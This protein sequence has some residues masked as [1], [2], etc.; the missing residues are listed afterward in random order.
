M[1]AS[2]SPFQVLPVDL[3]MLGAEIVMILLFVTG[4]AGAGL[5]AARGGYKGI[6]LML[7]AAAGT[8]VVRLVQPFLINAAGNIGI[9]ERLAGGASFPGIEHW[10]IFLPAA[11]FL[12]ASTLGVLAVRER[13]TS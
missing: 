4:L 2:M 1:M 12:F 13:R 3:A 10:M 11:T 6:Y 8:V 9:P 5:L 7:A